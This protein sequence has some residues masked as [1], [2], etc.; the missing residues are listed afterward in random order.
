M[1]VQ[2]YGILRGLQMDIVL[3][4][5]FSIKHLKYFAKSTYMFIFVS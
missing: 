4:E 2:I 3:A 1:D 5:E